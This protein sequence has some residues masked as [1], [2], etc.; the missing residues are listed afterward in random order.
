MFI[1]DEVTIEVGFDVAVARLTHLIN[2]GTLRGVSVAAYEGGLEVAVRVGP[3]GDA[4]GLS[5][6][7]LVRVL[8]PVRRGHT[9]V[10]ALRWEATGVAGE[11]FPV[12]DADLILGPQGDD[13]CQLRLIGSY[14]PPFGR[15]GAALDRAIMGRIAAA[16]IR[17]LLERIAVILTHP[18][19][20]PQPSANTMPGSVALSV[21]KIAADVGC[22]A[23][24]PSGPVPAAEVG[25]RRVP[26]P[27]GGDR[28]GGPVV[29][30]VQP[31]LSG[32]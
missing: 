10:A 9:A 16:T 30:T 1:R 22:E 14:R 8:E 6:L 11:L 21:G 25:V 28:R 17:S 31:V 13:R 3:F 29:P 5:K 26:V 24:E 20:N 27:A 19:P 2:R 12:L 7:V 23:G 4:P 15:A 18:A 32:H